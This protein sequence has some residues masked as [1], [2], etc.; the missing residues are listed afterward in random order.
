[1]RE[2]LCK[3]SSVLVWRVRVDCH[4]LPAAL[5]NHDA[6]RARHRVQRVVC[7]DGRVDGRAQGY[8]QCGAAD[9]LLA[10][11]GGV[12]LWLGSQVGGGGS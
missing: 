5:G 1:M 7:K 6:Y 3:L 12:R 9:R 2:R 11:A 4:R 10:E 8:A